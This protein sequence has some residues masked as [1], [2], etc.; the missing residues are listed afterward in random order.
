MAG[1]ITN[2]PVV[3]WARA[4]TSA[5]IILVRLAIARCLCGEPIHSTWPDSASTT[6]PAA[7]PTPGIGLVDAA[8]APNA[9]SLAGAWPPPPFGVSG[10]LGTSPGGI[11]P[12]PRSVSG[13]TTH[14]AYSA[15]PSA[16]SSS[17]ATTTSHGDR[18]GR[19]GGRRCLPVSNEYRGERRERATRA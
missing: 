1:V 13:R 6:R 3:R 8:P 12:A 17:T 18:R 9:G 15:M 16:A 10:R 7:A 4:A 2:V 14:R 11:T 5:V 19:I